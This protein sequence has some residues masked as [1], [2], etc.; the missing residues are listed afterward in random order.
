MA[1]I[2]DFM[3]P[4]PFAHEEDALEQ[5]LEM[6]RRAMRHLSDGGTIVLFPSGVVAAAETMLG[7][8][9]EAE[10][11]PFTA[12]MIQR[13]KAKV[14]PIRFP[15]Q[16][17]RAYQMAN[18]VS[19]TL[20]QGLLLHEVRHALDRPQRPHVGHPIEQDQIEAWA[21]NPRGFMAWLREQTLALGRE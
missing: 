15:G 14:V 5:N 6:R 13:S 3:I 12:K 9:V 21:G 18:R 4:V 11:S 10:W 1:E 8:A 17:S 19:A 16:N 7:E 20:R 2:E